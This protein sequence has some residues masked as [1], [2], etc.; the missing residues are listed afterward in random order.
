MQTGNLELGPTVRAR[1]YILLDGLVSDLERPISASA[2]ISGEG[3]GTVGG[4]EP[5]VN[6]DAPAVLRKWPSL[7]NQSRTE[8]TALISSST[9]PLMSAYGS[10]WQSRRQRATCTKYTPRLT[11][12]QCRLVWRTRR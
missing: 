1:Q 2:G 11:V 8:G 3:G 10:S 12:S 6:F 9:A 5:N 4:N 7:R